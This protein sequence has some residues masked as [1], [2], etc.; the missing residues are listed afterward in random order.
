M[1]KKQVIRLEFSGI[2]MMNNPTEDWAI[3]QYPTGILT[4]MVMKANELGLQGKKIEVVEVQENFATKNR[5]V[6]FIISN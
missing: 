4:K 6:D 2:D 5:Y 1:K 3:S